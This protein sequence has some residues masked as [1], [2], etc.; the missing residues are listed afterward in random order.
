MKHYETPELVE[1]GD[2]VELT[3]GTRPGDTIDQ[4]GGEYWVSSCASCS[5]TNCEN[6]QIP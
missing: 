3:L 1:L 2:A 4:S 5:C 6:Y